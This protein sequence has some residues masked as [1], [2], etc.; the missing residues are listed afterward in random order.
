MDEKIYLKHIEEVTKR[1]SKAMNELKGK[2]IEDVYFRG[3]KRRIYYYDDIPFLFIKTT[4]G[5]I[6]KIT[7][8]YWGSWTG[9]SKGEYPA[10]ISI[11]KCIGGKKTKK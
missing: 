2:T 4:D 10:F 5:T 11:E 7:G 8:G 6:F 9:K 3:I 1:D